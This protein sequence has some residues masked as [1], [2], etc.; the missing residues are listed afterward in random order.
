MKQESTRSPPGAKR[1]IP[2]CCWIDHRY[3]R[4]FK[5][6]GDGANTGSPACVLA[7]WAVAGVLSYS[8]VFCELRELG[9]ISGGRWRIWFICV[10][11]GV[12]SPAL[13]GGR[14]FWIVT[15]GSIGRGTVGAA[16]FLTFYFLGSNLVAV[17]M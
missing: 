1:C 12:H 3:R 13:M 5:D 9:N 17:A 4:I 7:A 10:K 11:L 6:R 15:P 16:T 8:P 14:A 2:R